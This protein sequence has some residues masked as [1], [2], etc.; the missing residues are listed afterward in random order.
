VRRSLP[1]LAV[2]PSTLRARLTVTIVF[3]SVLLFLLVFGVTS[4]AARASSASLIGRYVL[5]LSLGLAS[6]ILGLILGLILDKLIRDPIETYM[7]YMRDQGYL[8][9]EGVGSSVQLEID[10]LLPDEFKDLGQV[11]QDLL[12]QLIVRQAALKNANDQ[13][14]AAER[15]FRTVVNDSAEVKLLVRDGIVDIANPAAATCFDMPLGTMLKQPVDNLFEQISMS[16][17][18][19]EALTVDGLFEL[20]LDR[21]ATVR[22]DTEEHGERWMRVSVSEGEVPGTYVLTA[23]NVTEEHRLEA[24][25]AE[26]V[27]LVSHDLRAPLAVVSGYLEMLDR[28]LGEAERHKAVESAKT[29]A[30]R[31]SALLGDLLDTTRAEQVFAPAVFRRVNLG[32]LVDDIAESLRVGSGRGITVVKRQEAVALGDELRLR[33]AIENLIGNALKHTPGGTDITLTVDIT[34]NRAIVTVEDTG[35]GIPERDRALIFNRFARLDPNGGAGGAGL[36]LYIVRVIAESHGGTVDIEDAPAGGAR[37]VLAIPAAP[38]LMRVAE[39]VPKVA[40]PQRD[41]SPSA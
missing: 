31:M 37:F 10:P 9:I 11:I 28:P 2:L 13:I 21:A 14:L 27:S 34:A 4:L 41:E 6:M 40:A 39:T 12:S 23:R 30:N 33:Q 8:A 1:K 17:E 38:R 19:G 29:A 5:P 3:A 7:R 32:D 25:R 36:G 24:L 16:T 22:C 26:I 20:A 18:L 35:P 15:A